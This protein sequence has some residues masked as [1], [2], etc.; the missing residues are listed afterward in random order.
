MGM[1]I[2]R[3]GVLVFVVVRERFGIDSIRTWNSAWQLGNQIGSSPPLDTADSI[4]LETEHWIA[5]R[6]VRVVVALITG[7]WA[8]Q[9]AGIQVHKNL[10][11]RR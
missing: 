3:A 7:A 2:V 4:V 5:S 1:S 9:K 11:A 6:T 8:D 10:E